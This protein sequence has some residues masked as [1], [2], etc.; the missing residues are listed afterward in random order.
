MTTGAH[1]RGSSDRVPG[2]GADSRRPGCICTP[3]VTGPGPAPGGLLV[4]NLRWVRMGRPTRTVSAV[5]L[6]CLVLAGCSG[7]DGDGTTSTTTTSTTTGDTVGTAPTTGDTPS[8]DGGSTTTGAPTTS[9]TEAA[10]ATEP[11]LD[12]TVVADGLSLP[13]DVHFL[14]D[15]TALVTERGGRLL[16]LDDA[17][18]DPEGSAEP[19]EVALDLPELFVGSEAGLMGV[20]VSPDFEQD[21]TIFLC[22]AAQ[23]T[24]ERPD[25]RVTRWTL[26]EDVTEA[27]R[28]GVVVAG[29]PL[30]TGRH[31][32]CRL[33][34]TPAGQLLVG[35]GDAAQGSNPQDLESLG[36]KV[37]EVTTDGA[38][39]APEGHV[40]GGD[41]RILTYGHRN[42]QGLALQPG[43]GTVWSVEHGPDVDDEVNIL[44]PGGNYGWDP[45]PGYDESVPMTDLQRFPEA[46]EAVWSSGAPTHA[47]S[48]ATFLEGEQ[49]GTWDGALAVAELKGSGVTVFLVDEREITG[50]LRVP[51]LDGT[52]GRLRSLTLDPTGALWVTS[53]NG[54]GDVLLRVTAS[55]G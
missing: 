25:V 8:A 20:A 35:T 21:R 26:D 34:F 54:E 33:L 36:G 15:G 2:Q 45:T 17:V 22:H 6:G 18:E 46:V 53:S 24:G 41:P 3:V 4:R 40:E 9:T 37:L 39:A 11:V 38:P 30:S 5:A 42:V 16:A 29:M 43:T 28:D 1:F 51:E 14:P 48:G 32:G 47:T 23:A 50:S 31:S 49:W 12:V 27:A 7:G 13:W 52:H 19:R 44:E 10:P 55:T